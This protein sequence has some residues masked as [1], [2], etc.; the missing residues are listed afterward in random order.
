MPK[1]SFDETKALELYRAH[2]TDAEIAKG[3]GTTTSKILNWRKYRYLPNIS[4]NARPRERYD[5]ARRIINQAKGIGDVDYRAALTPTQAITMNRF[6]RA[7]A[8]AGQEC[9]KAGKKPN[10]SAAIN[11]WSG[12]DA[13]SYAEQVTASKYRQREKGGR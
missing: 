11:S 1:V 13:R 5:R 10:V 7:L 2:K 3:V 4:P 6:L 8:Y 9:A 12:R